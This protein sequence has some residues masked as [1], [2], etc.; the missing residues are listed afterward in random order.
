MRAALGQ[1]KADLV[2][3]NGTL[4]DVYTG[5]LLPGFSV[6]V[7][8]E[9]IAYV[10]PEPTLHPE[11]PVL[12]CQGKYLVPGLIDGHGHMLYYVTPQE[13]LRAAIPGG[14]TTIIT[15]T[16]ELAFPL[17]LRGV[18]QGLRACR[19]QPIKILVTLPSMVSISPISEVHALGPQEA[20][21]LLREEGV[22]GLGEVYWQGLL[23]G[24]PRLLGLVEEALKAGKVVEGHGAGARGPKLGAYLSAG[25]HS[26]HEPITAEEVLERMR[27]GVHVL[28]R[29]GGIRRELEAVAKIL[30]LPLDTRY[31]ALAS[32]GV[33]LK[34]LLTDGCLDALA[35]QAIKYGFTPV[36]A[37]QMLT[38]N[39]AEH[40]RLDQH[41]GGL[42]P[43][44]YADILVVPDLAEMRPEYVFSNG[45]MVA[46]EGKP[47]VTPRPH[48][49][50][51]SFRRSIRLT[52]PVRPED[53]LVRAPRADG[54]VGVR[55]IKWATPLV[56]REA[57][58]T[59]PVQGGLVPADPQRDVL[60]V[61]AIERVYEP[62]K[63]FVGF[64]QGMGIKEGALASSAS[65]DC[66]SLVVVGAQE[67]DM[68]QAINRVAELGGGA[69]L[70][71]RG[72]VQAELPLP[73]GGIISDLPLEEVVARLE[74]INGKMQEMGCPFPDALLSLVTL[75][76]AAIP[77]LR[78]NEE[79][80][81]SLRDNQKLGLFVE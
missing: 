43:G 67:E 74:A 66:T 16:M 68:A 73:Y 21:R 50:P 12:D 41:I 34:E 65:W 47:L 46:R 56:T 20:R 49:F 39:V 18:I 78:L 75:T 22:I 6:V 64:V 52:Q 26:D 69:V 37:I 33:D 61:A 55:V 11:S 17:G 32:D 71:A 53:F 31:L 10:G 44:R 40:F 2:L 30:E 70:W 36:Q 7:K 25:I 76:T 28:V 63:S 54:Q 24:N 4:V 27:L 13:F 60:K 80:L 19:D 59:L 3:R 1:E 42:A 35:R 79:G 77:F 57:Q 23:D 38:L 29:Q 48:P 62:G 14:T 9:R 5:E 45:K 81:V 8:G 51:R 15:E 72:R 58:L